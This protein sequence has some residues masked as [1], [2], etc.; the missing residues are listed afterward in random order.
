MGRDKWD[1]VIKFLDTTA[2]KPDKVLNSLKTI[3]GKKSNTDSTYQVLRGSWVMDVIFS[4][5]NKKGTTNKSKKIPLTQVALNWVRTEDYKIAYNIFHPGPENTMHEDNGM[6][7]LKM[8]KDIPIEKHARNC[9]DIFRDKKHK[10]FVTDLEENNG[11]YPIKTIGTEYFSE[12]MVAKDKYNDTRVE[13]P[14]TFIEKLT[15]GKEFMKAY[16]KEIK[17]KK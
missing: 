10:R 6:N 1:E 4:I 9:L 15:H 17:K 7:R 8:W 13:L 2:A 12:D 16:E 3:Y 14:V 11:A 5:Y